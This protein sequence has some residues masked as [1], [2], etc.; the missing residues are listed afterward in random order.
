VIVVLLNTARNRKIHKG[1]IIADERTSNS[2]S[3]DSALCNHSQW[4]ELLIELLICWLSCANYLCIACIGLVCVSSFHCSSYVICSSCK[5]SCCRPN[6]SWYFHLSML[7]S[8]IRHFKNHMRHKKI[9]S[10]LWHLHT[11]NN[12]LPAN[13]S[14][15]L[16]AEAD[17][18]WCINVVCC[19]LSVQEWKNE[20]L[21]L[22]TTSN[23]AAKL[24]DVATSQVAFG[25]VFHQFFLV[26]FKF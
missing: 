13:I 1:P 24:Y 6:L 22:S 11:K 9:Y 3:N 17:I 14:C 5:S 23:E 21:S 4:V 2:F 19:C 8:S 16:I 15:I 10:T 18:S 12:T 26:L 20:D 7:T 25:C